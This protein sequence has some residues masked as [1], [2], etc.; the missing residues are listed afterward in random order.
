M[1]AELGTLCTRACRSLHAGVENSHAETGTLA[2]LPIIPDTAHVSPKSKTPSIR[3]A[4]RQ[5]RDTGAYLT[6]P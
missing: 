6:V 3:R 4:S 1:H 2:P 5:L